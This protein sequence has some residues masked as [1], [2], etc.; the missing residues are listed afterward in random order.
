MY[1]KSPEPVANPKAGGFV[2]L[3]GLSFL[4]NLSKNEKSKQNKR[5]WSRKFFQIIIGVSNLELLVFIERETEVLWVVT[6]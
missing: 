1:G 4:K 2:S 6:L 3:E 5:K